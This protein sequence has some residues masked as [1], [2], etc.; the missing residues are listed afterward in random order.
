VQAKVKVER[1]CS[2]IVY[3]TCRLT[4]KKKE[5]KMQESKTKYSV[6][7]DVVGMRRPAHIDRVAR[8]HRVCQQAVEAQG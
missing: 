5:K 1:I 2:R 6:N 8:F 4:R 7:R 3:V